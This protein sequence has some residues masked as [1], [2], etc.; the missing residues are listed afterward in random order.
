MLWMTKTGRDT[1][2]THCSVPH[3]LYSIHQIIHSSHACKV[4]LL[5][6]VS[7]LPAWGSL[8]SVASATN[9]LS[10]TAQCKFL[11]NSVQFYR[12]SCKKVVSTCGKISKRRYQNNQEFQ[13][14]TNK[15]DKNFQKM[16]LCT[17]AVPRISLGI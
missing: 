14:F 8:K 2:N 6:Y 15:P 3:K 1:K 4:E 13:E 10:A 7:I 9:F 12:E 11:S 5:V 17:L 16:I